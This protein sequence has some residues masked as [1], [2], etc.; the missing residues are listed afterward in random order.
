M[1]VA[2][3]STFYDVL[4]VPPGADDAAIKA[5]YRHLVK[6]THPDT[7]APEEQADARWRF[8][9]LQEAYETLRDP[10][11]RAVYDYDLRSARERDA[12][13]PPAGQQSTAWGTTWTEPVAEPEPAHD[14][15]GTGAVGGDAMSTLS[16][17]F[18]YLTDAE[19]DAAYRSAVAAAE[20]GDPDAFL[21]LLSDL[22][23]QPVW[24]S[25]EQQRA[26]Q[27][28]TVNRDTVAEYTRRTRERSSLALGAMV[29]VPLLIARFGLLAWVTGSAE[30]GSDAVAAVDKWVQFWQEPRRG[31]IAA[32]LTVA[33]FVFGAVNRQVHTFVWN[34]Y[35]RPR[36][37]RVALIVG[38]YTAVWLSPYWT[39][40]ADAMLIAWAG[41]VTAVAVLTQAFNRS[42]DRWLLGRA[43]HPVTWLRW[44]S[45]QRWVDWRHRRTLRA[46]D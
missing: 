46:S 29:G 30:P 21:R 10:D 37:G 20:A 2:S 27:Q 26:P 14:S 11:R 8:V 31:I 22:Q 15:P 36:S 42:L 28:P 9:A 19:I 32:G 25:R 16:R 24:E 44:S 13:P 5:A 34:L 18:P 7:V 3:D 35:V 23:H 41:L 12:T 39:V 45:R 1:T 33:A 17:M 6:T 43:F 4:G 40:N 38:A